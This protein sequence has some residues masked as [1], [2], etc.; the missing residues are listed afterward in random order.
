M[1]TERCNADGKWIG[2]EEVMLRVKALCADETIKI[3]NAN[4]EKNRTVYVWDKLN[5]GF[6]DDG[7]VAALLKKKG[8]E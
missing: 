2:E 1:Y 7:S 8:I 4:A 3:N 6:E 5:S